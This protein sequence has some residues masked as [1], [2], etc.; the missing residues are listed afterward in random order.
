MLQIEFEDEKLL[1]WTIIWLP[2]I[3]TISS[4]TKSEGIMI[5]VDEEPQ[6]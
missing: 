1:Y 2:F 6:I 4:S 3:S 5:S